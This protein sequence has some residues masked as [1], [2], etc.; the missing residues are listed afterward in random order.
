MK[1]CNG[2]F[3]GG[4]VRGIGHVGAVCAM[5]EAGY[6]FVCL[7]GSSAGAIVAALLAAG[8]SCEEL[9]RE[10]GEL[11]YGKLKGRDWPDWFGAPGK[12]LSLILSLGIY[13]AGYLGRWMEA[14]L[15]EKGIRTFEDVEKG[16]RRLRITASDITDGKLLIL[17]DILGEF[18]LDPGTFPVWKAVL[19]S[20][21]IPVLFEPCRL[22]D[23]GGREHLIVDGGLLSN[24]P[25]WLFDGGTRPSFGFR[26]WNGREPCPY[27]CVERLSLPDYLQAVVACCLDAIDHSR[28]APGDEERTV[29]IS[30]AV[31]A[32]RERKVI[33]ATDFQISAGEREALFQNGRRGA[34]QFLARWDFE[35]WKRKYR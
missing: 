17:P 7:A 26:F 4:G 25:L 33:K 23:K 35:D 18:G 19:M 22:Q 6:R 3:E 15:E 29:K 14:L 1:F 16:G 28:I 8:Y 24:Y 13:N 9:H 21:S 27:C 31:G 20:A 5:E 12:G 32:E 10:I 11:D 34:E 2:V 30:T